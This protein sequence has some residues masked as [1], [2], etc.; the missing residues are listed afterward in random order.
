MY[1]VYYGSHFGV[2][3]SF[4]NTNLKGIRLKS[5]N[6]GNILQITDAFQFNYQKEQICFPLMLQWF[7]FNSI[8][9]PAIYHIWLA[10]HQVIEIKCNIKQN[11]PTFLCLHTLFINFIV[12]LQKRSPNYKPLALYRITCHILLVYLNHVFLFEVKIL[13]GWQFQ[14]KFEIKEIAHH[15]A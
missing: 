6:M 15:S 11:K 8:F 9:E 14:R 5:D 1:K 10:C 4:V 2:W 13:Y 3:L 7:N 12:Y